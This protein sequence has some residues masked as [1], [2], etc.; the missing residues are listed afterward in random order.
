MKVNSIIRGSIRRNL[1][2]PTAQS[3]AKMS[4][5]QNG[6]EHSYTL[7]P[8][9]HSPSILSYPFL[10]VPQQRL[11]PWS[12]CQLWEWGVSYPRAP[13]L[14]HNNRWH[15][16]I[17]LICFSEAAQ[18]RCICYSFSISKSWPWICWCICWAM[19]IS[20][21]CSPKIFGLLCSIITCGWSCY[22][23]Y[24]NNQGLAYLRPSTFPQ[25]PYFFIPTRLMLSIFWNSTVHSTVHSTA[26]SKVRFD[27]IVRFVCR[28][29]L[30]PRRKLYQ[31]TL[32]VGLS[33]AT[34]SR[35]AHWPFPTS[36]EFSLLCCWFHTRV[37]QFSLR[38]TWL[39]SQLLSCFSRHY[40]K[41]SSPYRTTP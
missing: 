40:Q 21:S 35:P 11:P 31:D 16:W 10:S 38:I 26:H 33:L 41:F 18:L 32:I 17:F 7:P 22:L 29:R 24:W 13:H 30:P 25:L 1:Q 14:T 3:W 4:N 36:T 5:Y 34:I 15:H 39:I 28:L 2:T 27:G 37:F 9:S 19:E 8:L 6:I 12:H 23:L 20:S